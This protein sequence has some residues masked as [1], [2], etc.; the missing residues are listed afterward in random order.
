MAKNFSKVYSAEL[1]GI[2]AKLIEVETDINVGLHSFNI[3]G[4]A[5]KAL[6]EAK[7]R[8][9]SA[10]KNSGIKPPTKENRK[11]TVNLAP[12]D[13]KKTGS[14]YDLAIA[15]GYLLATKQ[16]KDF[17]TR[18]KV[19]VGELSLEGLL[20]P[21]SGALNISRLAKKL[22][23]KFLFLPKQNAL[24][25]A[26]IKGIKIIPVSHLEQIINHLEERELIGIQPATEFQPGQNQ[27]LVDISEIKGQENA[28]RAL[29]VAAAGGHHLLMTGPPG[30]GKTMLAQALVSILP[31]P[32]LEEAI[33][34]TQIY[35]AAGL[36]KENTFLNYRPFRS[37]HHSASPISIIGGGTNPKPGEISLAHRGILFLDEIPE[38]RRDLLESLRQPLESGQICVSRAKNTLMFPAKFSLVAAMNPCPCGY[39][40]DSEKE[41]RCSANE[42]F[43]YQKKLSGPLLDRID[44]QIEVPRVK[45]EDLRGKTRNEDLTEKI[46]TQVKKAREIQKERFSK[47]KPKIHLNSELS[48]KQVDE[49]LDFDQS[50]ENF[51]KNILEKSFV[52]ARGYYRILKISQTIADLEESEKVFA[53][54]LAEAFQYRVR[55]R[56]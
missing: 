49:S 17:E 44:I 3:V 42:V 1:E 45:I 12:A 53:Q 38:F 26:V 48:S 28:K 22:N 4:L 6:N 7:E 15:I 39:F 8:V 5:D 13:I 27:S 55:E 25:A 35:S 41:C 54:H 31:A 29:I 50:A 51:L 46:K 24:E 9:S 18:D 36:L 52:S 21:V 23:F 34:I 47:T 30:A 33:E 10:L 11:I 14:Q 19:F 37:P 32:S 40:G 43:R 16:I 2:E 56:E 20:R